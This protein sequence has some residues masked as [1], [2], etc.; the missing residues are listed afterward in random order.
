MVC[1]SGG[2]RHSESC[3]ICLAGTRSSEESRASRYEQKISQGSSMNDFTITRGGDQ[4]FCHGN[5]KALVIKGMTM[6]EGDQKL[7]EVIYG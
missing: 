3:E 1:D 4:A 2:C 6:R 5:T 7:F